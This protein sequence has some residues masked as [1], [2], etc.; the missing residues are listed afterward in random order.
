MYVCFQSPKYIMNELA[1]Q[2]K[3]ILI[4]S[5]HN[6]KSE[7]CLIY[8][9]PTVGY[10]YYTSSYVFFWYQIWSTRKCVLRLI[11]YEYKLFPF[12]YLR[13]WMQKQVSRWNSIIN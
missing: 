2:A 13:S 7:I 5:W 3:K 1:K 10:T 12:T 11:V 6:E 4:C 9:Y 8:V